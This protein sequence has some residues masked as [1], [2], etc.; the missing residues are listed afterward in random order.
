MN[1]IIAIV[2]PTAVGKSTLAIELAKVMKG[3]IISADAFQFYLG[4]D[5]GTAKVPLSQR[6]GITHH[7]IDILNPDETFSVADYQR[8]VRAK[9]DELLAKNIT[10]ILVGGSGLY[11]QAVLYDYRFSGSKRENDQDLMKLS[12]GELWQLLQTMNPETA[13]KMDLSN[14]RR[15]LRAIEIARSEGDPL[16]N[17]GK[18]LFYNNV[19][20]IGLTMPRDLLYHAI[21]QR[22]DK[23]VAQGL[24]DEVLRLYHQGIHSQSSM[25]I[26]YKELYAYF[27]GKTTFEEAINLIKLHTRRYAKRQLT[28]FKNQMQVQWY[29]VDLNHFEKTIHD[30]LNRYE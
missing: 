20:I 23:M 6:Q 8:I 2:G 19:D 13:E 10:P 28:W 26:G 27:D 18:N 12:N 25:A 5:I 22:V 15:L 14:R 7:L 4:L 24:I 9:I 17:T 16:D 29:D 21:E 3:E 1:T 30:V 11:L